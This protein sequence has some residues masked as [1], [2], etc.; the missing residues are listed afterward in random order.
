MKRILKAFDSPKIGS[1]PTDKLL[2]SLNES[3]TYAYAF[4]GINATGD[5][6]EFTAKALLPNL[7]SYFQHF[8]INELKIAWEKGIQGQ[9]GEWMGMNPGNLLRWLNNYRVSDER[10]RALGYLATPDKQLPPPS[11]T[12]K[13]QIIRSAALQKFKDFKEN[14]P[15]FDFGS[16]TYNYLDKLGLIPFSDKE[17]TKILEAVKKQMITAKKTKANGTP[18]VF[19][20]IEL[21]N[22]IESIKTNKDENLIAA[23]KLEA[24]KLYFAKIGELKI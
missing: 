19:K 6:L 23:C 13:E 5:N 21:N 15:I 18:D 10:F 1:L 8:H 12:Y 20:R 2:P 4:A 11:D 22:S 9:Y 3:I 24:L 14:K 17:K 16:V 7:I